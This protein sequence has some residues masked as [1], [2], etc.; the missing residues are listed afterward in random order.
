MIRWHSS[1]CTFKIHNSGRRGHREGE[2]EYAY[3]LS[4]LSPPP[5]SISTRPDWTQL[6]K[7]T[8]QE[9]MQQRKERPTHHKQ[10][11]WKGIVF[12]NTKT[13]RTKRVSIVIRWN[14]SCLI[15]HCLYIQHTQQH[16][17]RRRGHWEGE[18]RVHL[19]LC[20]DFTALVS[21]LDTSWLNTDAD[22][23]TARKGATKKRKDQPTTNNNK[24]TCTVS[25]TQKPK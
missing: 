9:R 13:N 23:N 15:K 7:Q 12:K 1:C 24:G 19:L 2:R 5:Y 17:S 6:R 14:L 16:N 8:L 22:R 11:T 3:W 18:R 10:H 20:I 21:H 25:T 4:Y